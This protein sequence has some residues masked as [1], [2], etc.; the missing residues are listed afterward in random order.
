MIEVGSEERPRP[1][2][3]TAEQVAAIER[4]SGALL[5][6]AAA[7]SGKTTVLVERF[8]RSVLE[9]GVAP[10]SMLAIT[11]TDKAAGE[12]RARVRARFLE[13]GERRLAQETEAAWIST[14]HG[15]CAR[16]LRQHA[17]S[18]GLA[19][20]F[21]V[22][23]EPTAREL[24]AQAFDDALAGFL[25]DGDGTRAEALD[26]VAAYRP[27]RLATMLLEIY[28]ALRAA[29]REPRLRL[30]REHGYPQAERDAL[31]AGCDA[32]LGELAA[33]TGKLA[34]RA[35]G[36]VEDC[37]GIVAGLG[38]E[39]APAPAQ[40]ARGRFA[41]GKTK[42]LQGPGVA[43]YLGARDAFASACADRAARAALV[44]LDELL[45]R[46]AERY[47]AGKR[48]RGGLDY[49]D[50][51]LATRDLFR[52][53][54]AL[55]S[56]Y[57]ERFER[58][59]VDE[60]QDV[61]RL[62]LE[63]LEPL[64]RDNAFVVGDELQ[65]IY[66]FRHASVE[67]FRER[68]AALAAT[69]A[70]ASLQVN[71]RSQPEILTAVNRIEHA[72]AEPIVAGRESVSCPPGDPRVE[73][74]LC[75]RDAPWPDD[76]PLPASQPW[77]RA[78][79]RSVA[80]RVA[81]LVASG[82]HPAG[83]I[84]VLLRAAG[85]MATYERALEDAGLATLAA[86]GR[87]FW[88]RQQVLDL[89]AYLAALVNPRDERALLGVLAS[90][91][92]AGASPDALALLGLAGRER[93][94]ALWD[95]LRSGDDAWAAALP[96]A[97]QVRIAGFVEVFANERTR[98]ARLGLDTLL[99]RAVRRSRYDE[100]VLRLP[101]GVRR[102]ANVAKLIRLAAAF[103]ATRG[104]DVRA[105]VDRA[106][107]E[108]EAG[109]REPDAPVELAGLDAVRLM[110]MHA[111]KGLEFPVVVLADLGRAAN[112]QTPDLLVDE[113]RIGL[114]L[115]SMH[116]AS[117]PAL[118]Y[119]QLRDE[120]L[121]RDAEEE[122]RIMHV[123]MTRAEERLIL[124]GGVCL[125]SWP[126]P[127][128]SAAPIAWLAPA[129]APGLA[130][131]L[132]GGASDA[133]VAGIRVAVRRPDPVLA[134]FPA[135]EPT[136]PDERTPGPAAE[137]GGTVVT[138]QRD[139]TAPP[140]PAPSLSSLSYTALSR[141]TQCGYRFYLERIL[142]L[143]Q[144]DPPPAEAAP[145]GEPVVAGID[146]LTRGSLA[147]ELLEL[148][149]AD[150]LRTPSEEEVRA[151]AA[152]RD[153]ELRA[154]EVEDLQRLVDAASDN[155]VMRRVHRA[156]SVHHEQSFA[157]AL[158]DRGALPLLNGVVDVLAWEND[159][160]ALV[161]DYKT[162]RLEG[163]DPEEVVAGSYG[164]QRRIYALAALRAGATRVEVAHLFLERPDAPA[165]TVYE[166][167]DAG[168]LADEILSSA[169]ALLGGAFPVSGRPHRELCATCPGRG[170]L[171]SWPEDVVLR[172]LAEVVGGA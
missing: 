51:E 20:G 82:A 113:D 129:L 3:F 29:G 88:A 160:G 112:A 45:G 148:L 101:G 36:L 10:A 155:D 41:T 44:L 144:R 55:A 127:K 86:G 27:D 109:S 118:D 169:E 9:D 93:R 53:E 92:G 23:D 78:E 114:R 19:P 70:A 100:H 170:G 164:L 73:L 122:R 120:R 52:S 46:Y 102:L 76:D 66:G 34:E 97:E 64:E 146:A 156:R 31:A 152:L 159:G 8:V 147:H 158:D 15:F 136:E 42:A 83:D 94:R 141:Y 17:V 154:D 65:S 49:D 168:A 125:E 39:Q 54:P 80:A 161:V 134:L 85:D 151:Q 89:C 126:E 50:L 91:L 57:A 138:D 24:R 137:E 11:F 116:G 149:A 16:V 99:E 12:L 105:L 95:L 124:A 167:G 62:Q 71:F 32:A 48:E 107:S 72:G 139:A 96:A 157:V 38:A 61:N 90:P 110:T 111:A 25:D 7:G 59:M 22:L 130:E 56:A 98:A 163:A 166:T 117:V 79:A 40:L 68:R 4:R 1:R 74:L 75:D 171:C 84:V 47:A 103:E 2:A 153:V 150:E 128:S 30:P 135:D 123:A 58:L 35:R 26:L 142:R 145:G 104:R 77:R 132:A 60:F 67:V 87:G 6:S 165:V 133:V 43:A 131:A 14:I 106:L 108:L 162:D 13:L 33:A 21:V 28:D 172:P 140:A 37:A 119:A 63:L 81:E 5:V 69:G 115:V 121:A 143:P 18:A